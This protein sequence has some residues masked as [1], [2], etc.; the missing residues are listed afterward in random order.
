MGCG[1]AGYGV[2]E[3][4]CD[5]DEFTCRRRLRDDR[6]LLVGQDRRCS[7]L[8]DL[9]RAG[10]VDALTQLQQGNVAVVCHHVQIV[11]GQMHAPLYSTHF[12]H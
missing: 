5:C 12:F 8:G 9:C 11:P 2:R 6:L 7:I 10:V 1:V 3:R 4:G